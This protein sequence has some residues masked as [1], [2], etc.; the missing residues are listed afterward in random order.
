MTARRIAP[1]IATIAA[2]A[3]AL[4]PGKALAHC[5]TL[6]GPVVIE[7]KAALDK[8]DVTPVLKWVRKHDESQIRDL[9]AKALSVRGKGPEAREL[10]DRLFLE[11]L[12]RLHRAGEGAPYTGL[13]DEPLE[14]VI[15]MADQALADGTAE[16][17]GK[18]L[19]AHLVRAL[20]EKARHAID[21]RKHRDESVDAGRE[22]VKHYVA[23]MHYVEGLHAAIVSTGDHQHAADTES[24]DAH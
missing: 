20:D 11:T 23:Y 3:A 8:G 22:Y 18:R 5:D 14:P 12:V 2:I 9:F 15:V 7:A 19:A 4:L 16:N 24:D 6:R 10:A 17:M 21:A 13:K 1:T